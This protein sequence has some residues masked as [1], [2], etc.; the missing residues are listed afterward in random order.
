MTKQALLEKRANILSNLLSK[1]KALA[2]MTRVRLGTLGAAGTA[3]GGI[4]LARG[5]E[6]KALENEIRRHQYDRRQA[7]EDDQALQPLK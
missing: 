7:Q 4:L 2:P 1:W 5:A 6:N 3:T